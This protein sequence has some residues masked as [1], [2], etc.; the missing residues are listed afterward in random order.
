MPNWIF[1]FMKNK[2]NLRCI[3]TCTCAKF[4]IPK[5]LLKKKIMNPFRRKK[6]WKRKKLMNLIKSKS[7]ND[8][9]YSEKNDVL[10]LGDRAVPGIASGSSVNNNSKSSVGKLS[11]RRRRK[12]HSHSSTLE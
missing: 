9:E 6:H 10:Y 12:N 11:I 3:I 8:I 7:L 4:Q 2:K 5:K 1:S